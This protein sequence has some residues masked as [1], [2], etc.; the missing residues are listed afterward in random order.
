VI[1]TPPYNRASF[2]IIPSSSFFDL[3]Y[4]YQAF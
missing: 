2:P 1:A 4:Q 3:R